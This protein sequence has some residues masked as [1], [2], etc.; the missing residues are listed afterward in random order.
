LHDALPIYS[1]LK[2]LYKAD[3]STL[4]SLD[5][6]DNLFLAFWNGD[7]KIID[8]H[9]KEDN[10]Q[11]NNKE[12]NVEDDIQDNNIEENVKKN[13][14]DNNIQDKNKNKIYTSHIKDK[15][16]S[17]NKKDTNTTMISFN[18][19]YP[20][21]KIKKYNNLIITDYKGYLYSYDIN[22]IKY[23]TRIKSDAGIIQILENY[24]NKI[25]L[26]GTN[27]RIE[28]HEQ[29]TG[30]LLSYFNSGGRIFN[31]I[32]KEE[33]LFLGLEDGIMECYD[34][35]NTSKPII[36]RKQENMYKSMDIIYNGLEE[37]K[38]LYG[39]VDGTIE[40]KNINVEKSKEDIKYKIND[41]MDVMVN[42][43]VVEDNMFYTGGS[44][45]SVIQWN[46]KS[47]DDN[48]WDKG[49]L[50]FKANVAVHD[51]VL[52]DGTFIVGCSDINEDGNV[53][54]IEIKK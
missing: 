29:M 46:V 26:G 19:P 24:N 41:D 42:K 30:G 6:K 11:D 5:F 23:K 34:L 48:K 18:L 12:D 7:I 53:E 40:L 2:C 50:L 10:I 31:S 27:K 37:S 14:E 44:D 43:I 3:R 49:N 21:S 16:I 38:I 39:N 33:Y 28:I 51:A 47:K 36:V 25:I 35:R 8:L 54:V 13:I 20:I 1:T 17:H 4:T 15:N 52:G 9:T 22:N 32:L 45:G